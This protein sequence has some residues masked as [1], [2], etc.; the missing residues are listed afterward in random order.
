[1]ATN[2]SS[3]VTRRQWV[4]LASLGA[5]SP[6]IPL[7]RPIP[8]AHAQS[9]A[10]LYLPLSVTHIKHFLDEMTALGSMVPVA[11]YA[12]R[13]LVHT[14]IQLIREGA[15]IETM[16]IRVTQIG[17]GYAVTFVGMTNIVVTITA[18]GLLIYSTMQ[19]FAPQVKEHRIEFVPD[20][21]WYA[22]T[23]G[24]ITGSY[25]T[26]IPTDREQAWRDVYQWLGEH[27][28]SCGMRFSNQGGQCYGGE[29]GGGSGPGDPVPPGEVIVGPLIP[30]P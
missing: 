25:P 3:T 8:Q 2:N 29:F 12:G 6:L 1:M 20:E 27:P 18:A 14:G 13:L 10:V 9:G 23:N 4:T 28:A 26:G 5:V 19:P 7:G 15:T 16:S 11:H 30:L 21:E 22:R 17:A 24:D